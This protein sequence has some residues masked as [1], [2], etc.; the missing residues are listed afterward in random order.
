MSLS[1]LRFVVFS[2]LDWCL[3]VLVFRNSQLSSLNIASY[4]FLS[5]FFLGFQ[6]WTCRAIYIPYVFFLLYSLFFTI[7]SLFTLIRILYSEISS[8]SLNL[9]SAKPN[10]LSCQF[11]KLLIRVFFFFLLFTFSISLW[12]YV[13]V[14]VLCQYYQ[15]CLLVSGI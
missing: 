7:L 10:P 3:L 15:F 4:P 9:Y 12:F 2:E 8:T 13:I 1:F 14:L 5:L 11:S 6:L